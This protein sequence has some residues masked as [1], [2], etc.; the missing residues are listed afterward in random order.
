VQAPEESWAGE[1]EPVEAAANMLIT[2]VAFDLLR[3]PTFRDA[4]AAYIQRKLDQLRYPAYIGPLKVG[5]HSVLWGVELLGFLWSLPEWWP[6]QACICTA[7]LV[8]SVP[9]C[10]CDSGASDMRLVASPLRWISAR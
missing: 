8:K 3:A 7:G 4:A 9:S 6:Q 2:R 10:G 5:R 1:R